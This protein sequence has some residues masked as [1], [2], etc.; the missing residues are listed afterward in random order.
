MSWCPCPPCSPCCYPDDESEDK[1]PSIKYQKGEEMNID[2][3]LPQYEKVPLDKVFEFKQPRAPMP[4]HP[5]IS[6]YSAITEQPTMDD[7]LTR[8]QS[9]AL[10]HLPTIEESNEPQLHFSLYYDIQRRTLTVH[11]ME[12]TNIFTKGSRNLPDSF[13]ILFL[14]PNKEA[15]FESKIQKKTSN[16]VFNEVFEFSS[17]LP[18]EIRRQTLV[19]R[20]IDKNSSSA[21]N[22]IGAVVLQLEEA[23]LYGIRVSSTLNDE[24]NVVQSGSQGDV[25]ISLMYN[26]SLNLLSGIL[27]KATNLQRMDISGSS[28]MP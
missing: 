15:I 25:L 5:Q 21:T 9:T 4:L 26:P 11:L 28:G 23:D 22:D 19:L 14:L 10:S 8:D 6:G 24:S 2:L 27:L 13:V 20:V 1:R 18:N 12:G 7:I 3:V 16:P 17:L